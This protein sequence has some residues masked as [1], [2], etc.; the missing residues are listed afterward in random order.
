MY[1]ETLTRLNA[2]KEV[3]LRL[4]STLGMTEHDADNET[5]F[6]LLSPLGKATGADRVIKWRSEDEAAL[7]H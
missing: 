5:T 7:A 4:R 6:E 1:H 3:Q 2:V